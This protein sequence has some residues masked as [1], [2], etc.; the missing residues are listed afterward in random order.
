MQRESLGWVLRFG[1]AASAA[2]LAFACVSSA[3][4]SGLEGAGSGESVATESD[5][6]F[7]NNGN[8]F[9]N[10]SAGQS[11]LIPVCFAVRPILKL[12]PGGNNGCT[13]SSTKP[14]CLQCPSQAANTDC[15]GKQS[16]LVNGN[17]VTFDSAALRQQVREHIENTWMRYANVE[18]V[19]WGDCAIDATTNKHK[20]AN[21]G[22]RIMIH[23]AGSDNSGLGK[24]NTGPTVIEFNW[25]AILHNTI[26]HH[27]GNV[28]HEFGHALGFEHEWLRADW[29]DWKCTE[30]S[31]A[32]GGQ[33]LEVTGVVGNN[34]PPDKAPVQLAA[35][36]G[37]AAQRWG[38]PFENNALTGELTLR[39]RCL[40]VANNGT[41]SHSLVEVQN[42][43]NQ[44][45]KP[46]NH[47]WAANADGSLVNPQSGKCLDAPDGLSGVQLQLYDCHG[48]PNQKFLR[49]GNPIKY[50]SND[51][52]CLDVPN[53]D[54]MN[55]NKVQIHSCNQ[56]T[57]QNF[58]QAFN[59]TKLDGTLRVLG[60]C[61]DV[62]NNS[63]ANNAK[64]QIF[65]CNGQGNQEWRP[66]LDG[67]IL[68]PQSGRCLDLPSGDT[69]DGIQ[70]QIHDCNG[71]NA[72]KWRVVD[73][74]RG[75]AFGTPPDPT[76]R[77]QYCTD[78]MSPDQGLL[79]WDV[80]GVQNRYGR[81]Y[82]GSL[83]GFRGHCANVKDASTTL[84]ASIINFPCRGTWNDTWFRDPAATNERFKSGANN[85]CL[86]VANGSAPNPLISF[87][88]NNDENERFPTVGVEWHAM[89]NM[90]VQTSSTGPK[91]RACDSTNAGQKWDFF[92]P[93]G[94]LLFQQIRLS[95]TNLC[96][97]AQTTNGEM[98]QELTLKACSS[99]DTKQRFTSTAAGVLA[100]S[101]NTGLCANVKGGNPT[102]GSPL[103]LWNGCSSN[104]PPNS[105]FSLGGRIKTLN[106]CTTIDG[107][108]SAQV[109]ALACNANDK[110]QVWEYYF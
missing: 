56:G 91:L 24:Q 34:P 27:M 57:N 87:T 10:G 92:H 47:V 101:N 41:A 39:G 90:C 4:D 98:G 69:S 31:V 84:G 63:T 76:S 1:K 21:L 38:Q 18:F 45:V 13:D 66:Q 44:P 55:G 64:V 7:S 100:L 35:C 23:F 58:V 3:G 61:L 78:R 48:G 106:N 59:G 37:G 50:E 89:G 9:W 22:G 19:G 17:S 36:D 53:G 86:N 109:K 65:D 77:M 5:A 25:G 29:T 12:D 2:S 62:A 103:I 105:K 15:D 11:A 104:A 82:R 46:P 8:I 30:G 52:K 81:K 43:S 93:V 54:P 99:G 60:K 110:K 95:G 80:I 33:C 16:T 72:Q 75:Q 96:V 71:G 6:L 102:P 88:C 42:C 107:G 40:A 20:E 32:S 79:P 85:R 70:L 28:V 51:Q 26:D 68:N 83:V 67:S 97:A 108:P 14:E 49:P 94:G 73:N 74:H